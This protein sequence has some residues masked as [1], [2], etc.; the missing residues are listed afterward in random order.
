MRSRAWAALVLTAVAVSG[1][2]C[3]VIGGYASGF[4]KCSSLG[5]VR[6]PTY[7][8]LNGA[9]SRLAEKDWKRITSPA[10]IHES[11]WK[12]QGE[13]TQ[14]WREQ[15]DQTHW[16]QVLPTLK[17][18]AVGRH[19]VL[20]CMQNEEVLHQTKSNITKDQVRETNRLIGDEPWYALY[21]NGT[22]DCRYGRSTS[23]KQQVLHDALC[24]NVQ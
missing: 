15:F 8:E 7:G 24:P 1:T 2:T 11:N 10:Y 13:F 21:V 5:D 12:S 3:G 14:L 22:L 6:N 18:G 20:L 19:R 23:D 4:P 9:F 17:A 16:E